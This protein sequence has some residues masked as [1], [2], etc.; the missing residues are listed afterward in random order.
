MHNKIV[1]KKGTEQDSDFIFSTCQTR[2][3]PKTES[4]LIIR[5]SSIKGYP[6]SISH[7]TSVR[8]FKMLVLENRYEY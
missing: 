5:G 7:T 4:D 1:Y 3:S 8:N 6:G 2:V